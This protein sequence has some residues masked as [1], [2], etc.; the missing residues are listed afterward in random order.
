MNTFDNATVHP[1]RYFS[2]VTWEEVS[3]PMTTTNDE[4]FYDLLDG[5]VHIDGE[6]RPCK[7]LCDEDTFDPDYDFEVE[8]FPGFIECYS[9]IE[10]DAHIAQAVA[11]L[12]KKGYKTNWCCEGHMSVDN[13]RKGSGVEICIGFCQDCVPSTTPEGFELVKYRTGFWTLCKLVIPENKYKCLTCTGNK[14]Y[15]KGV[16]K[17]T[18]EEY[19]KCVKSLLDSYKELEDWAFKIPQKTQF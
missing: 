11:Y 16:T 14:C 17:L 5:K 9:H 12:N 4:L 2:S 18:D 15:R 13:L 6:C 10:L 8:P 19:D 7:F 1:H 3:K